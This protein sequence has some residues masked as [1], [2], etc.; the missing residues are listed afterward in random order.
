MGFWRLST[1]AMHL[2]DAETAHRLTVRALRMGAGPNRSAGIYPA[3]RTSVA[4]LEFPNP[5]GL[6]AGFDKNAEVVDACLKIGFGFVEAGAVT[7]KPQAGNPKPRV[8]RLKRDRAVINRY[9]FNND[10]LEAIAGRLEARSKRGIVGI[11]LG[12]NKDSEDRV[13]DYVTCAKRLSPSVSFCTVNVSSPNTPGLRMM[14]DASVLQELLEKV[15]K[16][17]APETK[18]FLKIAPDLSDEDKADIVE[19]SKS[20]PLDAL[21]ISN[22]TIGRDRLHHDP[23]EAG[24]LSGRPLFALS[25]ARL[26]EFARALEGVVPLVGVGGILSADDAYEKIL[27][28]ASLMQLYTGMVFS[29]PDLV[30][31]I[32]AGLVE[33]L[34]LDGY[35]NVC[36]AVGKGL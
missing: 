24:G 9:G 2:F 31:E 6:A 25:T 4:G 21:I 34:A 12:A 14:Q 23:E 26:A 19:V 11:N 17:M 13:S 1:Q 22:T 35:E 36:A 27:S 28:G 33:R 32:L 5:L 20:A 7:P 8:F 3:L 30:T 15:R 16:V 10:G 18:L 29:G